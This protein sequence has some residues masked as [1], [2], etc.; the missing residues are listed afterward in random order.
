MRRPSGVITEPVR[1][2]HPVLRG[3]WRQPSLRRSSVNAGWAE[4]TSSDDAARPAVIAK[5]PAR[6]EARSRAP[7]RIGARA[8][9]EV[10]EREHQRQPQ[11]GSNLCTLRSG[12]SGPSSRPRT[13]RRAGCD[14]ADVADRQQRSARA[15]AE[16]EETG[17]GSRAGPG[18]TGPTAATRPVRHQ[19]GRRSA[20]ARGHHGR[21]ADDVGD[22][23][24]G[25]AH[26]LEQRSARSWSSRTRCSRGTAGCTA[27]QQQRQDPPQDTASTGRPPPR[28][29]R[30]A[31]SSR[32]QPQPRQHQRHDHHGPVDAA[33]AEHGEPRSSPAAAPRQPI[34]A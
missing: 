33:H 4:A 24:V 19:Q 10:R 9:P 28:R 5:A 25:A 26:R 15:H 22:P 1:G 3:S 14:G 17:S 32:Q 2:L 13:R 20:E 12:A 7:G 6:R 8:H 29:A 30:A 18:R 16:R 31:G 34:R 11:H 27:E 21:A 23:L